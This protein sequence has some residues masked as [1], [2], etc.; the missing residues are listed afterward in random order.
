MANGHALIQSLQKPPKCTIF[1]DYA[2]NFEKTVVKQFSGI[3]SRIDV[4]FD[5]YRR[6]SFKSATRNKRA[7]QMNRPTRKV[8]DRED[9]PLP[10]SWMN[11]IA[12]DENEEDLAIFQSGK[13]AKHNDREGDCC[14]WQQTRRI[15]DNTES[16][17]HYRQ[18]TKRRTL[19][20]SSMPLKPLMLDLKA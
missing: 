18:T 13:L 1:S 15:F 12:I 4:V 5:Q 20:S 19:G 6:L 3:V 8:I 16:S 17:Q 10:Q 14:W 9:L 7:G 11:F 2:K